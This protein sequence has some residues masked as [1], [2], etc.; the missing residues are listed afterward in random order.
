MLKLFAKY[1]SFIWQL[2]KI[3]QLA[4]LES[5]PEQNIYWDTWIG[6]RF[7]GKGESGNSAW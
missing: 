3:S 4:P 5:D 6:C 7:W 2:G 1:P